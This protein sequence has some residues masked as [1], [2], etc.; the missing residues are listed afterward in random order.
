[1]AIAANNPMIDTTIMISTSVNPFTR[2]V[3]F[4]I[5]L[6]SFRALPDFPVGC[7]PAEAGPRRLQC[8]NPSVPTIGGRAGN[9]PRNSPGPPAE[10]RNPDE[11]S[12]SLPARFE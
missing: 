1:M 8:I 5:I 4:F 11:C 7:Y 2:F 12:D 3:L 6:S 9:D 10:P